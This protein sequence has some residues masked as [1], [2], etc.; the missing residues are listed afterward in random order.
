MTEKFWGILFY[1]GSK[2]LR[3]YLFSTHT[4]VVNQCKSHQKTFLLQIRFPTVRQ[5]NILTVGTL[6]TL[7]SQWPQLLFTSAMSDVMMPCYLY[8]YTIKIFQTIVKTMFHP[9]KN[10]FNSCWIP[11]LSDLTET[12]GY[13][14][15]ISCCYKLSACCLYYSIFSRWMYP[16]WIGNYMDP[17]SA[18]HV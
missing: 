15:P 7:D 6:Q 1:L 4:K 5:A 17:S 16:W 11:P 9:D 2:L 13:W 14:A 18:L 10:K 3:S 8:F 12:P